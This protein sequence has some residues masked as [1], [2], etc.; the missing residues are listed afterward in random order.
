MNRN[1]LVQ[2]IGVL[3]TAMLFAS[4]SD[5]PEEN[6]NPAEASTP[7]QIPRPTPTQIPIRPEYDPGFLVDYNAQSGDTLP[8][9]AAHFNTT[10]VEIKLANPQIPT[11]ATT[12]PAGMPMKIPIYYRSYW[13][14]AFQILPDSLFINGPAV[15]QFSVETFVMDR[16]GWLKD[17]R[18]YAQ[19]EM[20]SGAEIVQLVATNY[21]ISPRV[22]LSILEYQ[23]GA[24]SQ[25]LV[26]EGRYL[27][28]IFDY[29]YPEVYMQL[30]WAAN[31]LNHG[32]YGWRSGLLTE[33]ELDNKRLE[34]P[35][36]WQT[37]ATVAY[38]YYY[39][40][41][42]TAED[43]KA[44][45]GP[46]G[47]ASIYTDLFG[48]PWGN[49]APHIP[50]SL[51]QPLFT[52]PFLPGNTWAFTGGPHTGWGTL[53]PW[54]ALDFAPGTSVGGCSLTTI[55]TVAIAEGVVARSETGV[56]ILDLDGDGDER[57]GWNILYLHVATSG[58]VPAGAILNTGDIIGYPSCE[59]GTATGTHIHI[60][61]KY[62]GEWI[63]AD[64]VIPFILDGWIAHNGV[65]PYLGTLTRNS[66][67]IIACD[68]SIASSQLQAQK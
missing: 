58:R 41:L 47:I 6:Q 17:Y 35:D 9:L 46:G 66:E 23:T 32:Y 26:P 57:T 10:I 1:L 28:G 2:I 3:C 29:R 51:D 7:V 45:V 52:L 20:R 18:A 11:D 61:R 55:P 21:S 16:P 8:A 59:G 63:A 48:D 5:L 22:L 62:N 42:F 65:G 37:S 60:A 15:V 12:L 31:T 50:V 56:V 25:P 49:V 34:R 53:F 13:G 33:F 68:C 14:T 27:L 4:C 43:Y 24:L 36:P 19:G 39:S 54:A 38:Q 40:R 44:A 64:S 30:V 67:E